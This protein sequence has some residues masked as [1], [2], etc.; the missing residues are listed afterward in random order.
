MAQRILFL[1]RLL[2][3][4]ALGSVQ[5]A[6]SR[7]DGQDELA[8]RKS[9]PE[10]LPDG[11]AMLRKGNG[12]EPE[13]LDPHKSQSTTS[14]AILRDLYESLV[15]EAPNGDLI[16]GAA[17]SWELS[18]DGLAYTFHLR[19]NARW[20]NGQP[21]TAEDFAWS[22]RRS[23]DPATASVYSAVLSPILNAADVAAAKRP[24][25]EL[26]VEAVDAKTL[27]IRLKAPTPY[28]L[29]LLTHTSTYPVYRPVVEQYADQYTAPGKNVSN[30]AYVIKEWVVSSHIVLER[31]PQYWDNANTKI[32][33]VK[34][35]AIDNAE[36]EF[37]RYLAG[38]LDLTSTVPIPQ[39]DWARTRLP[40][41]YKA[42]PSISTYYYGLN[43]EQPPFK[44]NPKLRLALSMALDRQILVQKVTR[45]GELPAYG[46]VPPGIIN[47]TSQKPAWA[48]WPRDRQVA[49]ARRLY[50][51]AGYSEAKPLQIEIRYNTSEGHKKIAAAISAM[52]KMTLGLQTSLVNEEWKV[53]LDNVS[54]KKITQVYRAGWVGDYNDAFTFAELMLS[55]F[56]LNG[57]GYTSPQYDALV[58]AA[59][60]EG[61]VMQRRELL[62]Q[63][64]QVLLADQPLLPIYFYVNKRLVKPY[65]QG[66]K[67]NVMDHI[68]TK[69]LAIDLPV[70]N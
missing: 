44:N 25:A 47:Y 54:A 53:L 66:Y 31:N 14:S 50:S 24:P 39:L 48:D 33:L 65:V 22:L 41:E 58:D 16:P 23:V 26:G 68:Y 28:F 70:K 57:T 8:V 27:R 62:Q 63:A 56:G 6:C 32:D 5:T 20:S 52:W 2:L 17:E 37:K 15:G 43:L 12:A 21:V 60:Y 45:G 49:E 18:P 38:E 55:R 59:A 3:A 4:L 42:H 51:E 29:G 40:K 7:G 46:W 67:G 11:R 19:G 9:Q 1:S 34:Y 35:L 64:E 61:D 10:R 30:G 36:S 69:N 13:S